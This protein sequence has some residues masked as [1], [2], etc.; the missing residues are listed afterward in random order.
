MKLAELWRIAR[1]GIVG[2]TAAA[3]HYWTVVVLVELFG[4]APLRANIGG[5]IVAFWCSYFGHRHWT[6][7][8]TI[9][10]QAKGRQSF[11]RFLSVALLGFCM[12]ALLFFLFLHY[13]TVPYYVALAIVV[14][15]VAAMTYLL[16][17]L[18]AFRR[19]ANQ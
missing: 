9:D 13:T 11:L 17:R 16:S 2:L 15:V 6:F 19:I 12:N 4:M 1:F 5:F 7:S 10:R 8:D 14:L 18:W 3:I